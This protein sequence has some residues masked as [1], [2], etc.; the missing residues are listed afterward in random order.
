MFNPVQEFSAAHS[1][2]REVKEETIA[3][4][5]ARRDAALD[6]ADAAAMA[7]EAAIAALPPALR[8]AARAEPGPHAG[9]WTAYRVA[10]QEAI[11]AFYTTLGF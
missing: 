4:A 1:A 8:R 5:A 10:V 11:D 2:A 9:I 6:A 7:A 3:A